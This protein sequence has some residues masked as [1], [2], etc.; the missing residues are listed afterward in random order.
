MQKKGTP[1]EAP[2]TIS[3]VVKQQLASNVTAAAC[4]VTSNIAK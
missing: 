3:Y 1:F 2:S 4:T